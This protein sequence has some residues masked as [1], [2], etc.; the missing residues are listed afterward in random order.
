M[1]ELNKFI[2][3]IAANRIILSCTLIYLF[4]CSY[5]IHE[6][7]NFDKKADQDLYEIYLNYLDGPLTQEKED[8]LNKENLLISKSKNILLLSADNL[9]NNDISPEEFENIFRENEAILQREIAFKEVWNRYSYVYEDKENRYFLKG[10]H[11]YIL[12]EKLNI[13]LYV[14]IILVVVPFLY[15]EKE[16][17]MIDLIRTSINGNIKVAKS[18]CRIIF[19]STVIFV[20]I[21]EVVDLLLFIYQNGFGA[22]FYPMQ[23]LEIFST[24]NYS[25]NILGAFLI[26]TLLRI[27]GYVGFSALIIIITEN[28]NYKALPYY[29]PITTLILVELLIRE[30]SNIY[31][32][33]TPFSLMRATGFLMGNVN[34]QRLG[35]TYVFN[36]VRIEFMIASII[37][38]LVIIFSSAFVIKKSYRNHRLTKRSI[39]LGCILLSMII[40]LTGC[41][42][43]NAA[44]EEQHNFHNQFFAAQN[45]DYIFYKIKNEIFMKNKNTLE[46]TSMTNNPFLENTSFSIGTMFANNHSLY[47]SMTYEEGDDISARSTNE[48]IKVSLDSLS[49]DVLWKRR[50]TQDTYFMDLIYAERDSSFES[51][52][53]VFV[54]DDKLYAMGEESIATPNFLNKEKIVIENLGGEIKGI[55]GHQ[56][57]Y[58]SI[59]KK[60]KSYDLKTK[61]VKVWSSKPVEEFILTTNGF[62]YS[63]YDGIGFIDYNGDDLGIITEIKAKS[64]GCDDKNIY[65]IQRN[66]DDLYRMNLNGEN[67]KKIGEKVFYFEVSYNSEDLV[68]YLL[69]EFGDVE[70]KVIPKK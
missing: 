68:I 25:F 10:S 28:S 15:I 12:E 53:N 34:E 14:G 54:V 62:L 6:Y 27:V 26:V 64:L 44:T 21:F 63:S 43:K 8:Y 33:P 35:Y 70:V 60:I 1:V 67:I 29:L 22:L 59:D 48:I 20:M 23:S 5:R 55:K 45:D 30:K 69:N 50:I 65:F 19:T 39:S 47:Y 51:I 57:F 32:W 3:G 17:K 11:E 16:N 18:K 2:R 41:R 9:F 36:E 52:F 58:L 42:A 40:S 38:T 37:I 46:I 13:L 49:E 24:S 56:C 61:K 66:T 4:F 7:A 31:L